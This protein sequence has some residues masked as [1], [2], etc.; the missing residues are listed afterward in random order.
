MKWRES[1]LLTLASRLSVD[2]KTADGRNPVHIFSDAAGEGGLAILRFLSS[3]DGPSPLPPQ[4][5]A[6]KEPRSF[7]ATTSKLY[8]FELF[9]AAAAVFVAESTIG[10]RDRLN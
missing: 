7:A 1:V 9:V 4:G 5:E 3:E 10:K 2:S 8:I 6:G